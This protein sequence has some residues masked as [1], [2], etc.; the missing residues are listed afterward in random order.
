MTMKKTAVSGVSDYLDFGNG[1]ED[2]LGS[3]STAGS[4]RLD[5]WVSG[6]FIF[7]TFAAPALQTP[8]KPLLALIKSTGTMF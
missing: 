3:T 2:G 4:V 6:N 5:A 1:K 8:S 7:L